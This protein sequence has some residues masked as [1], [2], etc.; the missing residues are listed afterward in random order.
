MLW[1]FSETQLTVALDNNKQLREQLDDLRESL[2]YLRQ[3]RDDAEQAMK[4]MQRPFDKDGL[5]SLANSLTSQIDDIYVRAW[6]TPADRTRA[7]S[8]RIQ[9]V[10]IKTLTGK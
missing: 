1:P 2:M 3:Q 7:I 8:L 5:E 10:I 6:G 4:A 9:A